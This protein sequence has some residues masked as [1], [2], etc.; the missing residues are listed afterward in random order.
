[1]NTC[2]Y[3]RDLGCQGAMEI[4][5]NALELANSTV[6]KQD[7]NIKNDIFLFT[8]AYDESSSLLPINFWQEI[9]DTL[10]VKC[11]V[12]Q[13][14]DEIKASDIIITDKEYMPFLQEKELA[15]ICIEE[16]FV[17][18]YAMK[19]AISS[20]STFLY[21]ALRTNKAYHEITLAYMGDGGAEHIFT[22]NNLLNAGICL[23]N[24]L[25][26]AFSEYSARQEETGFDQSTLD[27]A[28]SAGAKIFLTYSP[29]FIDEENCDMLFLAPWTHQPT[30]SSMDLKPVKH[31]FCYEQIGNLFLDK[32]QIVSFIEQVQS[33]EINLDL[34]KKAA[35]TSRIA[36]LNY[37]LNV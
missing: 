2:I 37:M 5:Q 7:F 3:F 8:K 30:K 31:P 17:P 18:D 13:N 36:T 19:T 27:F 4:L 6:K 11:I 1:M 22:T 29:E 26:F 24:I 16:A 34:Y 12:S 20:F 21:T 23:K 35:I 15:N 9:A 25:S 28:M 14:I 32:T 10:G 33:S